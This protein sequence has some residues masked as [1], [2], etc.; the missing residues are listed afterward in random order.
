M[1]VP[2]Q[3]QLTDLKVKVNLGKP[4]MAP[5]MKSRPELETINM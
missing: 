2:V 5:W 3:M 4:V 1:T